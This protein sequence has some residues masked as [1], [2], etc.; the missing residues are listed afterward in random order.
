MADAPSFW[1]AVY[2]SKVDAHLKSGHKGVGNTARPARPDD[3]LEVGLEEERVPIEPKPIRQLERNLVSLDADRRAQQPR[4]LLRVLQ[5]VAEV[6]VHDA[7]AADVRRP[8]RENAA[9][10]GTGGGEER[11]KAD[12]LI[13]R[14]EQ[15]AGNTETPVA[16][17][18]TESHEHLVEQPIQAPVTPG[19][20]WGDAA[21]DRGEVDVLMVVVPEADFIVADQTRVAWKTVDLVADLANGEERPVHRPVRAVTVV[22]TVG[23]VAVVETAHHIQPLDGSHFCETAPRRVGIGGHARG[24]EEDADRISVEAVLDEEVVVG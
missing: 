19:H 14:D 15:G 2:V 17:R 3:V 21:R 13:G 4:T 5:V 9:D 12:G 11:H 8:R 10:D 1:T 6:S 24:V 23:D 18:P 22:G 20:I 16:A 7:E